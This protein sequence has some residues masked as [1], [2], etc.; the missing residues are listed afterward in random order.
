MKTIKL[1]IIKKNRKYFA[2]KKDGYKCK[3]I[4]NAGSE[5]LAIGPHELVVEDR[6]VRT[7]YGTDLIYEIV[8]D[9]TEQE[10]AGIVTLSHYTY[11]ADLV[12]KCRDLGGRWDSETECWVFSTIV[13]DEV[14]ELD[15]IYNSELVPIEISV[16]P[17]SDGDIEP[18]TQHTGPVEFLG[19]TIARA[20]GR[21]SGAK[22][23]DIV[24]LMRGRVYSSGSMKNWRSCV[25]SD[26]IIRLKIPSKLLDIYTQTDDKIG[27]WIIRRL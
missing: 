17:N 6:S 25:S 10:D 23:G 8:G 11:N 26:A 20:R 7:K 9:A 19:Y 4:I 3:L 22:I 24:S 16:A 27:G 2:C 15:D 1:E 21:D 13:E 5:N 14:E 12:E 18:V